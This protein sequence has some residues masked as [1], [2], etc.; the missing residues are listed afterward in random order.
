MQTFKA[1]SRDED[2]K[3]VMMPKLVSPHHTASTTINPRSPFKQNH[4]NIVL[5]T[6]HRSSLQLCVKSDGVYSPFVNPQRRTR[7]KL[8]PACLRVPAYTTYGGFR[9]GSWVILSSRFACRA[10]IG[11]RN[12]ITYHQRSACSPGT[13]GTRQKSH[14][15]HRVI[16]T[17]PKS[18]GLSRLPE[19]ADEYQVQRRALKRKLSTVS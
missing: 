10:V 14:I 15:N 8:T 11:R 5:V 17:L 16:R 19:S 7:V 3:V 13:P 12:C 1:W 9:W 2:K 4:K 18:A 6:G